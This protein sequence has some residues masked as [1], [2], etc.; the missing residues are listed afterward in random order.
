MNNDILERLLKSQ[1]H[2]K[3]LPMNQSIEDTKMYIKVIYKEECFYFPIIKSTKAVEIKRL[4]IPFTNRKIRDM[5]L[6]VE[7]IDDA[8]EIKRYFKNG[9]TIYLLLRNPETQKFEKISNVKPKK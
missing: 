7:E 1:N 2:S 5:K 3:F 6:V 9:Q 8:I 4:L